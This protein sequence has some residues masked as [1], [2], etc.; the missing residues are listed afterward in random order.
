MV[1]RRGFLIGLGA[2][3]AAPAIVRADSLM[4]LWVPPAPEIIVPRIT[5]EQTMVNALGDFE[6]GWFMRD[7]MG[8]GTY[9][10]IGDK[11]DF[12]YWL[13]DQVFKGAGVTAD[14]FRS[15]TQRDEVELTD[16]LRA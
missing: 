9:T 11:I 16:G 6:T 15:L 13:G 10:K 2:A 3:I 7:G 12:A 14:T 5:M 8:I 1:G 4:K